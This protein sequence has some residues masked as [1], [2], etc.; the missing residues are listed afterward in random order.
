[1]SGEHDAQC[2]REYTESG[3]VFIDCLC[4]IRRAKAEAWDEC[5]A[6]VDENGP[7]WDKDI[8]EANP[9][10]AAQVAPSRVLEECPCGCPADM[11][12]GEI[13]CPCALPGDPPCATRVPGGES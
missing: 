9:Y 8:R 6:W 4:H 5:V 7:G 1:M 2:E 13:G 3:Y 10:R 12:I 11:H